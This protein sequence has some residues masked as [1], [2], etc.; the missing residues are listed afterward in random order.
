MTDSLT[1]DSD[2]TVAQKWLEY[3][4]ITGET[5]GSLHYFDA[6][7][8][9]TSRSMLRAAKEASGASAFHRELAQQMNEMSVREREKR[10]EEMHGVPQI[11]DETPQ[12]V[13]ST[14]S[15]FHEEV[16]MVK[17]KP[18]YDQALTLNRP[19]IE[20]AKFR[21]MFLRAE[22]FNVSRA[23]TRMLLFLEKKA[24]FFG[25]HTIGRP[26]QL[27]DLDGETMKVLRSGD[28]QVLP[29][30]D[31]AGRPV[32]WQI[33]P[34]CGNKSYNCGLPMVS[35]RMSPTKS[36]ARPFTHF[37]SRHFMTVIA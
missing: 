9:A 32:I 13:S 26:L 11:V 25:A 6:E 1:G 30:R 35:K 27:S 22:I 2:A 7:E 36:L 21:L 24:K 34:H 33:G 37:I 12:M 15:Q 20:G 17:E 8:E 16:M 3:M 10:F 14:L 5:R 31:R 29:F 19:Y 4:A 18:W 23:V 28:F